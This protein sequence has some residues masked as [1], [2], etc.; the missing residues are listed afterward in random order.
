MGR[1]RCVSR[2]RARLRFVNRDLREADVQLDKICTTIG[3]SE[4]ATPESPWAT[5]ANRHNNEDHFLSL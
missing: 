2:M 4:L 5:R 1:P 3:E